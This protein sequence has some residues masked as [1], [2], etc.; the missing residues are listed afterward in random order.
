MKTSAR[1]EA[2]DGLRFTAF[3]MVMLYHY[4]RQSVIGISAKEGFVE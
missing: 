2:L 3:M 1:I 4:F